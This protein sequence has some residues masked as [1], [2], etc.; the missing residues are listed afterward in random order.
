MI[1]ISQNYPLESID[2]VLL[3]EQRHQWERISGW[4]EAVF[5]WILNHFS[6]KILLSCV[7]FVSLK[8]K[9]CFTLSFIRSRDV[10][11]TDGTYLL[12]MIC[13]LDYLQL[14]ACNVASVQGKTVGMIEDGEEIVMRSAWSLLSTWHLKLH[15]KS[16]WL[17][18]LLLV[19]FYFF[20]CM[21]QVS[22]VMIMIKLFT[23]RIQR[24]FS[25]WSLR[26]KIWREVQRNLKSRKR[27]RRSNLKR[28]KYDQL[29]YWAD[30]IVLNC[31][32]SSLI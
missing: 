32:C 17:I 6:L 21:N 3:K 19:L 30:F 22:V 24:I 4:W 5:K 29:S 1:L 8:Y 16:N 13:N 9:F 10:G 12:L 25:I 7:F 23:S 11:E 28:Y 2:P 26:Q 14:Q 15:V 31:F 18:W 20:S 27:K